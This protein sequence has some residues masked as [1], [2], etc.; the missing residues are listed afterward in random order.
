MKTTILILAAFVLFGIFGCNSN[1]KKIT[2]VKKDTSSTKE[3]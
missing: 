1:D 3:T 2:D